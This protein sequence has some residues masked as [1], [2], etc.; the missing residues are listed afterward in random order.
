MDKP[1]KALLVK[2]VVCR[3]PQLAEINRGLLDQ[4]P[5][6]ELVSTYNVSDSS[7][8]RHLPH[9]YK[10]IVQRAQ[11]RMAQTDVTIADGLKDLTYVRANLYQL[12]EAAW[13]Q[14]AAAQQ[15]V[16]Y[17]ELRETVRDVVSYFEKLEAIQSAQAM[18]KDGVTI[19]VRYEKIKPIKRYLT[20]MARTHIEVTDERREWL[21][22]AGY[23]YREGED[24]LDAP[25]TSDVSDEEID[26][27]ID[28]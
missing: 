10:A 3:H 20:W 22:L 28:D 25:A 2:C 18:R 17:R 8:K 21:A 5:R 23:I 16:L 15:V 12:A 27:G 6:A 26:E 1:I 14:K 9:L 4:V 24:P 19:N 11:D 7:L 13:H